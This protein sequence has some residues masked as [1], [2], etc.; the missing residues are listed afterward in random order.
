MEQWL[1]CEIFPGQFSNEFSVEGFLS[2]GS[3][4]SLFAEK[5]DLKMPREPKS[6]Q[7]V[8]GWIRVRPGPIKDDLVLVTLPKPTFENGQTITV[9]TSQI[10]R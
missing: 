2:D 5:R 9:K 8:K 6:G 1:E 10:K 7:P 4:F 3:G